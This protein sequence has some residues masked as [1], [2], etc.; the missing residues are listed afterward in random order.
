MAGALFSNKKGPAPERSRRFPY[1]FPW[2]QQTTRTDQ[3]IVEAAFLFTAA[4]ASMT[5]SDVNITVLALEEHGDA[6]MGEPFSWWQAQ[7]NQ[8]TRSS[9]LSK[10]CIFHP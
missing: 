7:G 5:Q 6:L 3:T 9:G 2:S 1:G 8:I 10:R 4:F